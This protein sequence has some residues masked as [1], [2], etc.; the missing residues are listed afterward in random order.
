V[1]DPGIGADDPCDDKDGKY[2]MNEERHG[3]VTVVNMNARFVNFDN[4]F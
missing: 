4:S 1:E 3:Y 2:C